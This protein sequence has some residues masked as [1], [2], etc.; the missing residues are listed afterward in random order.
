MGLLLASTVTEHQLTREALP[1]AGRT[2]HQL[3]TGCLV[4]ARAL[5][6]SGACAELPEPDES[7]LRRTAFSG[8]FGGRMFL[9]SPN[10][11]EPPMS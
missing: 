3:E 1:R 2:E 4:D 11:D 5:G 10:G 6:T 9:A 7:G 8:L